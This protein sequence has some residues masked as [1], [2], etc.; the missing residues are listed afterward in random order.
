M[1]SFQLA[2]NDAMESTLHEHLQLLQNT[3]IPGIIWGK[4]VLQTS[5]S[6]DSDNQIVAWQHV[7]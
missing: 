1:E 7:H 3:R 2:R 5:H 4:A 6:I